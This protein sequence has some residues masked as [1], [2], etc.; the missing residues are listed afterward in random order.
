MEIGTYTIAQGQL[1]LVIPFPTWDDFL[2]LAFDEICR[3]GATSVQVMRRMNALISDLESTVPVERREGLRA[4]EESIWLRQSRS[5]SMTPTTSSEPRSPI[6]RASGRLDANRW[7]EPPTLPARNQVEAERPS[8]VG[9]LKRPNGIEFSDG[10]AQT[11]S[12][13]HAA[14]S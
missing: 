6:A 9:A 10:K 7:R 13:R 2:C 5:T 12:K 11:D 14:S 8:G 3:Y 4:M 1:R